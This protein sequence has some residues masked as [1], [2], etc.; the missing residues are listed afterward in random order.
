MTQYAIVAKLQRLLARGIRSEAEAFYLVGEVRKL[1]EQQDAKKDYEYL[2]FHCD[3]AVH[4][5][6]TRNSTAQRI[7]EIFDAANPH[8]KAGMKLHELPG[9]LDAQIGHI[10]KM[11][12]FKRELTDFL[13]ANGLPTL[14]STRSD[15]WIHFV[16]FY[17]QIVQDCPLVMTTKNAS[18][19]IA[20]VTLQL[21][22]ANTVEHGEV[23]FRVTWL[24]EDKNGKFG[25]IEVY[26]SF[27]ENPHGRHAEEISPGAS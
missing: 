19:T 5:E 17:G 2:A 24:I 12:Y 23:Y 4:A 8:L 26:N 15:G 16:H 20:R 10:S 7:L 18:A 3:W 1:L 27:S 25:S 6:L 14:E 22:L 21:E 9:L 11:E 13:Q